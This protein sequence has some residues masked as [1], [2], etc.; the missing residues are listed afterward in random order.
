[1]HL[2]KAG[3]GVSLPVRVQFLS[4]M[5]CQAA[6]DHEMKGEGT[7]ASWILG[8]LIVTDLSGEVRPPELERSAQY[9]IWQ[10]SIFVKHMV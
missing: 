2:T 5:A 8:T 3:D 9:S 10:Q 7:V 6:E 1:M 4:A